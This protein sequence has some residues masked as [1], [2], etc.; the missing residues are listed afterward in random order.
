MSASSPTRPLLQRTLDNGL[1]VI[2]R[3]SHD[4]PVVG[5]WTWYRVGSRNEL[6]GLT[7]VSHW[8]E[9]MQFKGTPSRAKGSIFRD[10][11]KHGGTLNAMTSH[12]WT[13]YYETLPSD[14]LDLAL[15]IESDRMIN[16][17]YEVEETESERTVI[18]SERQGAENNPSYVLYE[19]I[20][21]ESFRAHPYRHMV[22][23]YEADLR[24]ISRDD[25][26][27]HYRRHY[28]PNNAFIAAAGDFD[29]EALLAK[30]EQR[31]GS[32]EPGAEPLR[33]RAVEPSQLGERRVTLRRPAPTS[34]LR[35]AYRTPD[36][37]HADTPA[38][39]VMDAILSG[40]S[41]MGRSARLYK[42]LVSAG[43]ARGAGSDFSLTI[44]PYL[45]M[46]SATALPG[47]ELAKIEEVL[48]GELVLLRENEVP[49]AELDRAIKQVKA[50]H[51]YSEEGVTNQGFWL[52]QMEIVD[53]YAR[54]DTI[55]AELEA[56]TPEDVQRVAKTYLTEQA[57]TVG[58]LIPTDE[59]GGEAEV[60][61]EAAF[62]PPRWWGLKGGRQTDTGVVARRTPLERRELPSGIVVLGQAR[63]TAPSVVARLRFGSGSVND[64][65]SKDGLAAFVG[66]ML[67]RGTTSLSYEAFNEATDSLGATISVDVSRI[68]TEFYIRCLSEDLPRVLDL[69]ADVLRNPTF[70]EDEIAKVRQ[71]LLA[72]I[73]EQD[74]DTRS[75]ADRTLRQIIYPAGHPFARRVTGEA[76][77]VNTIR[78][79]DL[80]RFH[81]ERFGPGVMTVAVVG[82]VSDI[83]QSAGLIEARFG[84]WNISVKL[85]PA[86]D[87]G[88]AP[89]EIARE[90][91][92]VPGKSQADFA[93]G[94][95]TIPRSHPDYY[96]LDTA[97]LILGRLGLFGR[98]GASVR[99]AQ[100]L[101]YYVYSQIEAGRGG[102]VWSSRAG[103][104]PSNVDQAISSIVA[105]VAR[106][107]N[108]SVT[109]EE[110]D[111]AKSYLTG[112]VPLAFETNDGVAA[113]LLNIEYF[114]LGLDYLD[115]YPGIINALTTAQLQAAARTHLD[116]T[117]LAVGIAGPPLS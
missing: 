55:V 69:A 43:L 112:I 105:E 104:N 72:A 103:V 117:R 67:I 45:F 18:I 19:E 110:L 21:G 3:E 75:V 24:Q 29:A 28:L 111:D 97:N 115:R 50:G 71:E 66:R 56:V 31:F 32:I 107:Q 46:V 70:P 39:L 114:E 101:A 38:L 64:P 93:L 33:P 106:I 102:S 95:P 89:A 26:Y 81:V 92:V 113:T 99:D 116:P 48:E 5:F 27:G 90:A 80:V 86:I 73:R 91:T 40:S 47:V 1:Q 7:G 87:G 84:D 13:A 108:E 14:R 53:T 59:G 15:E 35:M 62:A 83:K 49:Q 61:P 78:R 60:E 68:H 109:D 77:T 88:A 17:I 100:G 63:P 54:A 82:G 36:S 41:G 16:S 44:D 65:A 12:D 37:R 8:V 76:E 94:F 52:G 25:L 10:V 51:V 34:Y 9:H 22:I 74:N 79:D 11:S 42:A 4:A 58:W 85:N 96:A 2:L 57:R 98:L 6:P 30:I 20:V 23:G